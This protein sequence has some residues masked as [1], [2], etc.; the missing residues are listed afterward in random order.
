MKEHLL[1][2]YFIL[3]FFFICSESFNSFEIDGKPQILEFIDCLERVLLNGRPFK[4]VFGGLPTSIIVRGKKHFFRFTV[5]PS[6]IRPGY[7]KIL[8]MRGEPPKEYPQEMMQEISSTKTISSI[9]NSEHDTVSQDSSELATS[10]MNSGNYRDD[11]IFSE[12]YLILFVR[13]EK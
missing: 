12:T 9:Q 2:R 7:V 3:F 6:G 13:I 1:I 4:V 8:G 10:A 5:L 11:Y